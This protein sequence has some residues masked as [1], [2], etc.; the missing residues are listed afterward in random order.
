MVWEEGKEVN[1]MSITARLVVKGFVQ[2]VGYRAYVKQAAYRMK[3]KGTVKNLP[4]GDVEIFCYAA[5]NEAFERFK[6]MLG[7]GVGELEEIEEHL[8]GTDEYGQGPEEWIGFRIL[9]DETSDLL[10]SLEY[11]ILG[12]VQLQNQVEELNIKQD[13]MLEKQDRSL[14]KQGSMLTKQDQ[15]LDA[16]K[17]MDEHMGEK[18]DWL[19]DRY[20]EFGEKMAR[21]EEDIHEIKEAFIRL[22]N[23][24]TNQT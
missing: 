4:D 18:F 2:G 1:R 14:E 8:K 20:G 10:E 3:I 12:G 23:H 13:R 24:V 22:V 21:L 7:S 19:G 9:R 15:T 16:I 5:D 6:E 17:T 11:V